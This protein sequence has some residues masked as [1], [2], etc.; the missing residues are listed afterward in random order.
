MC[1]LAARNSF[2]VP[3]I[4]LRAGVGS[5]G[6]VGFTLESGSRS[7]SRWWLPYLTEGERTAGNPARGEVVLRLCAF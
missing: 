1:L 2:A 7:A 3:H 6:V 5:A 4:D